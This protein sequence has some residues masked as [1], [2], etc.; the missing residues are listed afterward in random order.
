MRRA[1]MV[2]AYARTQIRYYKVCVRI[3]YGAHVRRH[4]SCGE[5]VS[6]FET[7]M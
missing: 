3:Q 2:D 6:Y 4:W 7:N 1:T 5:C